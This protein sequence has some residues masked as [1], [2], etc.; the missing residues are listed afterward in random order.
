MGLSAADYRESLRRYRPR[1]FVDRTA[2]ESVADAPSLAP[3]IAAIGLAGTPRRDQ[4]GRCCVTGCQMPE[5]PPGKATGK[6]AAE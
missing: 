2:I 1:V 5:T 4:P 6:A 3:G